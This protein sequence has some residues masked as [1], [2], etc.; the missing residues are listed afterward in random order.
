MNNISR[1]AFLKTSIL[2]ISALV[3]NSF[4][5]V[6]AFASNETLQTNPQ[7]MIASLNGLYRAKG[8]SFKIDN[9][10]IDSEKCSLENLNK[11]FEILKTIHTTTNSYDSNHS[12]AS[13]QRIPMPVDFSCSTTECLSIMFNEG[14]FGQVYIE[15]SVSGT[16]DRQY[17]NIISSSGTATERNGVNVDSVSI[18]SVTTDNDSPTKGS[19]SYSCPCSARFAWTSPYSGVKYSGTDS[20]TFSGSFSV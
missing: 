12:V 10:S 13:I 14:A 20:Q 17:D 16:I 15:I 7:T 9:I 8:L 2:G 1:K 3:L 6:A 18:G 5:T 4:P 11:D 19:V